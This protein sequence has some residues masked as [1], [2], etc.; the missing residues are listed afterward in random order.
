VYQFKTSSEQFQTRL[1]FERDKAQKE[2][3]EAAKQAEA[4]RLAEQKARDDART[5]AE[6]E[7][8]ITRRI[9]AQKPFLEKRLDAYI[10][11][12]RVSSRLTELNLSID[13]DDWKENAKR[14]W[15]MRWGELEMVG[16]PGIR[17]AARLVG[18]QL[19]RTVKFPEEDRH[20]LRWSVEC[21]ADELR[22]SLE[23]TWGLR[24][25]AIRETV[26]KQYVSKVPDG[27][28]QG[29]QEAVRPP[30]MP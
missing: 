22:F 20:V 18:E 29:T 14:F 5:Y 2:L 6:Q 4:T 8:A 19:T 10:E 17:N 11:A 1:G 26:L 27:C 23:H 30:G 24:R 28:N 21:L 13:S 25:S 16:D 15:Q 9:E 3:A 12:I 7:A